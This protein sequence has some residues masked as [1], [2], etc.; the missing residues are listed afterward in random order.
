PVIA[1]TRDGRLWFSTIRGVLVLDPNH[2][3]RRFLSPTVTVE[4]IT[5]D[6]ERRRPV[7]IGTLP[8]GRN[9]VEFGYAGVSFI[10]P[11]R[12]SFRY[13]LDGFDKAWV[14][15]GG[16]REAFYTNLPPGRFRFRVM[17][18]NPDGACNESPDV[19]AFV[20]EPRF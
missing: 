9:N 12:I 15:A 13:K 8:A 3:E 5:V 11:T 4:T 14:E 6:G 7:E 1:R 10:A 20:I 16:R 2:L 17:A 18:C 19:V